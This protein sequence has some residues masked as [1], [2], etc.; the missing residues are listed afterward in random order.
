[1]RRPTQHCLALIVLA[2]SGG[3]LLTDTAIA[4]DAQ[5]QAADAPEHLSAVLGGGAYTLPVYPGSNRIEVRAVPVADVT[6]NRLFLLSGQG[7]G[8]YLWH[9]RAWDVGVSLDA[10]PLHRYEADDARLNGLGN[11]SKTARA[12]VFVTRRCLRMEATLK[13]STDIG[14]AGHGN[15][16]DLEVARFHSLTPRLNIRT[17]VGTTWT[18]ENYMRT[19]FAVDARQSAASGLPSF[20]PE[21]GISSVRIFLSGRYEI[22]AHWLLSGQVYAARLLGDAADSPITQKRTTVGGGVFL[23]YL[24]R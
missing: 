20:S 10:D 7:A 4:D 9:Q 19:F 2:L 22:R 12:N 13:I 17:G 14:G 18:N 16:V 6:W 5:L 3:A 11:V 24:L 8:V 15:V 23:A 21:G 1:M